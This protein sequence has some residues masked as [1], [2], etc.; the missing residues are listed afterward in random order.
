MATIQGTTFRIWG[1]ALLADS[2][3]SAAYL[4]GFDEWP[5]PGIICI[6]F[7]FAAV[8]SVPV[9]VGVWWAINKC[10]MWGLRG[11][12]TLLLVMLT[13]LALTALD[14]LF[15]QWT[16]SVW[17]AF[18][19]LMLIALCST[20]IGISLQAHRLLNISQFETD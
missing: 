20:A 15:F 17:E 8:Y 11:G 2:V 9:Y 16:F 1:A 7:L 4:G 13:G 19:N 3:I 18:G 10:F 5:H 6:I 12:S 14:F